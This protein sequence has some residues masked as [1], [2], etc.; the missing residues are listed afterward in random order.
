MATH[1][2]LLVATHR[3]PS[4]VMT[5]LVR[6]TVL[7]GAVLETFS[8]STTTTTTTTRREGH[9]YKTDDDKTT[10]DDS[11]EELGSDEEEVKVCM[12]CGATPC[13]WVHFQHELIEFARN[14][15][16][17]ENH[18]DPENP[19]SFPVKSFSTMTDEEKDAIKASHQE[20]KKQCFRRY[21]YLKHGY[22][23][24]GNRARIP[25]CIEDAIRAM[26]PNHDNSFVGY[27]SP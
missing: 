7:R 3:T 11:T 20:A 9:V 27:H 10:Y 24:P 19:F 8:K 18:I 2:S 21:T 16:F 23:G 15:H 26:F 13:D 17:F 6:S 14:N 25:S 5:R 1:R 12:E 4:P 22:M